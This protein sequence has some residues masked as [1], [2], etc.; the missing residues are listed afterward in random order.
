MLVEASPQ[1]RLKVATAPIRAFL[2]AFPKTKSTAH[3]AVVVRRV[4]G[5]L[6]CERATIEGTGF[7]RLT[8]RVPGPGSWKVRVW[9][10]PLEELLERL[11]P[12]VLLEGREEEALEVHSGTF[13]GRLFS[14]EV[15]EKP[16]PMPE[17][18]YGEVFTEELRR[19][20]AQVIPHGKERELVFFIP[21]RGD[22]VVAATD[23]YTLGAYRFPRVPFPR[24]FRLATHQAKLFASLLEGA[25]PLVRLGVSGEVLAAEGA[26]DGLRFAA[27]VKSEARSDL[28]VAEM[29]ERHLTPRPYRAILKRQALAKA[30][31]RAVKEA[32]LLLQ[33][34][35]GGLRVR[36]QGEAE[37]E[38]LVP[39]VFPRAWEG[40][41]AV[42]AS[43]LRRALQGFGDR[44]VL[45]LDE[46]RK[47]LALFSP[48]ED[49]RGFFALVA[50][51]SA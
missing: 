43:L 26:W 16:F 18:W 7:A 12:Q 29:L 33:P 27:S 37:G 42:E 45:A 38:A 40:E 3:E 23:G 21:F 4:P 35:P 19:A 32:T 20:L 24:P 5:E 15:D 48:E 34:A 39:A 1:T 17:E 49:R 28:E 10:R 41:I 22:L 2:G 31:G 47:V 44:V 30:L 8:L 11:P 25:P 46:G 50:L 14:G 36:F 6:T 9:A 51:R 13:R